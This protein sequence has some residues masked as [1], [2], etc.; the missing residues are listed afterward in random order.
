[1]QQEPVVEEPNWDNH[2]P[3]SAIEEHCLP[4]YAAVAPTPP[5]PTGALIRRG[6]FIPGDMSARNG[7][8]NLPPSLIPG[9]DPVVAEVLSERLDEE[10]RMTPYN[11]E[12]TS[13]PL[14]SSGSH[15]SGSRTG[16]N[17]HRPQVEEVQDVQIFQPAPDESAFTL[18]PFSKPRPNTLKKTRAP[19][20]KPMPIHGEQ[21][22]AVP[23]LNS[24]SRT[25]LHI[26]PERKPLPVAPRDLSVG[27]MPFGP[28]SYNIINPNPA[29]SLEAL[30]AQQPSAIMMPGSTRVINPSDVLPP[31]T[32]AP[33]PLTTRRQPRAPPP[34]PAQHRRERFD[35][36]IS[37]VSTRNISPNPPRGPRLSLPAPPEQTIHKQV[38][39]EDRPRS[40][41]GLVLFDPHSER[42]RERQA[43]RERVER[44]ARALVRTDPNDPRRREQYAGQYAGHPPALPPKVPMQTGGVGR[45]ALVLSQEL[46]LIN[47]G[48]G[49]GGRQGRRRY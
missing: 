13:M 47:L 41:G 28:D 11:P 20:V 4:A 8:P 35:R 42:E 40:G 5:V 33:E 9:L 44:D 31:H 17:Y 39:F 45:E 15:S 2:R 23:A 26:K 29:A 22:P 14:H 43:D 3:K 1:M 37:L 46:S 19:M 12:S 49:S 10:R 24:T 32:H 18:D 48:T 36:P 25:S 6:S 30:H 27:A 21:D 38:S 16:T 34:V 7:I